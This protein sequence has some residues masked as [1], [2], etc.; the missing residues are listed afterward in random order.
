MVYLSAIP[1][2]LIH[3]LRPFSRYPSTLPSVQTGVAVVLSRAE[4]AAGLRLGGAVRVQDSLLG[5]LAEPGAFL[6]GC[7]AEVYRV[8]AKERGEHAGGE[9]EVDAGHLLAHPVDVDGAAAH[10]AVLL[11]DEHQLDA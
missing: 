6:V 3:C 8:A 1:P 11:G 9:A 10:P 4:V 2:L 5:D 7:G